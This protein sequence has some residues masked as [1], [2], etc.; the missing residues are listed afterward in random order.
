MQKSLLLFLMLFPGILLA[1]LIKVEGI[2][3]DET[4]NEPL[5]FVNIVSD[6]GFGAIT[7]IDGKFNITTNTNNCC[8]NI[9][10]IGYSS[11]KYTINK[12][13]NSQTIAL[14][15][16]IFNLD[17]VT[18]IPGINP[19]HRII[20]N[21]I[22]NRKLNDPEKLEAFTYTSYDKM[23]LTVDADSILKMDTALLDTN[24]IKV[25]KLLDKQYLFLLETVTER[26]YMSPGLNQENVLATRVSGLNDPLM[27][28]MISQ[29]QSTS[30]Y[31]EHIQIAGNDYI[32][33]ISRGSTN[34]Y[35]FLIEDT[36][37]SEQHD[38]IFIISF[39]P[40]LNTKFVGM[41]GFLHINSNKWA[42]Q[43]V[44][45]EPQNDSIGIRI[46]IQQGYDF[47][48]DHWFPT[49]LNT[50]IVFNMANANDGEN[51][52]PLIGHGRSYIKDINLSPELKKKD[53]SY[54]EIEIDEEATKRKGEYWK[55]YRVDSLTDKEIETYRVIDS[56]GKAQN[57]DKIAN[58]FQTVISGQIPY[59]FIN[60]DLNK[61]IH[62]N[63]YEGIY[64]GLGIHTNHL[65]SKTFSVGG[66]WGY[67]FRDKAAK[68][69]GDLSVK[70]HK[71]SESVI[72]LDAYNNLT[73]SGNVE[74]FDDKYQ[75]WRPDNFYEFFYKQ[76]NKTVGGEINYT[77]RI[78]PL[79]DFK[80]NI[81]GKV[82]EKYAYD[83]Y[84]FTN[85]SNPTDTVTTFNTTDLSI[86]FRFAYRE[87]ILQT[88]KGQISMG[89]EFPII[90]LNLTQGLLGTLNGDFS[91][92]RI[93][94][95]IDY[96]HK[97]K[98]LGESSILAKA[99]TIVGQLPISNLYS[100]VGTYSPFT[101]YAP[102]SFGTMRPNEFYS[103][104]YFSLFLSHNFK[105]LLFSFGDYE[106]ELMI[107]TNIAFGSM[108]N[109]T[110]HHQLNFSTLNHGYYESGIVIRKLLNLQIYDLGAGV[111]Y[112]Y[113]PYG[114]ETPSKNFAYKLSLYYT[115]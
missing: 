6:D 76:M 29:I 7:D 38:T 64:L 32:N 69:G 61:I 58:T 72:R 82:Q 31:D 115:F 107:V 63:E 56:I 71:R 1:Q 103:D 114:F 24:Q 91:F 109:K 20:N 90:W 9:S 79:R 46:K 51:N 41:K 27:A 43:N 81:G 113:G 10:Y 42:I 2:I 33:P 65:I 66:Y 50:D 87:K 52:Y 36:T 112:R 98:Y 57:F 30:F 106:P 49:Q 74:F 101:I 110:D 60:I 89:S 34:K 68:Y 14:S 4:N 12:Y 35:M 21:V 108:N 75:I 94:L 37:Y 99:G 3:I 73:A 28:F 23:I 92:S 55:N 8:L 53:F 11:L 84:Y 97:F 85:T 59:K 47:I 67:G 5:A 15:P 19:A 22:E 80:W 39:R 62:Y 111:L 48:Q 70:I 18:I 45:A 44:K 26:K 86:G 78:K 25:R 77:F 13:E 104:R 96:T 93:D 100:G 16:T 88:T 95:K 40:L 105:N 17:E 54:H 83:N 102:G